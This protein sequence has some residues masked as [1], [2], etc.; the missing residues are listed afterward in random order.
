MG[1]AQLK[2]EDKLIEQEQKQKSK[3]KKFKKEQKLKNRL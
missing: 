1:C 3:K 2:K